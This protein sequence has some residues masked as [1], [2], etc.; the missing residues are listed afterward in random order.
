MKFG[1]EQVE[2]NLSEQEQSTW[3]WF[4]RRITTCSYFA[5][6]SI[7]LPFTH[8]LACTCHTNGEY[9]EHTGARRRN[10][11]GGA[12]HRRK[13]AMTVDR[14]MDNLHIVNHRS[15]TVR[16]ILQQEFIKLKLAMGSNEIIPATMPLW[17]TS[18]VAQV[19]FQAEERFGQVNVTNF[20]L[21]DM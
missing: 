4:L 10:P 8:S 18:T 3:K 20:G 13:A 16:A 19:A 9:I 6:T 7:Y 17:W 21:V 11:P 2:K 14:W 5:T 12:R 1:D 15:N